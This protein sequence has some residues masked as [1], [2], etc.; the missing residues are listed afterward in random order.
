MANTTSII[1]YIRSSEIVFN[2]VNLKP[3]KTAHFFFDGTL[4]DQFI[5]K[6]SVIT[7][8]TSDVSF[9]FK[10]NEGLYCSNTRSYA[11]VVSTS[12]NNIIY[13]NDNY[14]SLNVSPFD[15]VTPFNTDDFKNGD[16]VFTS[17]SASSNISS[18][19]Y[20]ARVQYFNSTDKVLVVRSLTG[21][22]NTSP[23]IKSLYNLSNAKRAN[24]EN[25]FISTSRFPAVN[26]V[27]STSN[28]SNSIVVSTYTHNHGTVSTLNSSPSVLN[29]LSSPP[30]DITSKNAYI[31][32]GTGFPNSF[33]VDTVS[34]TTV[35]N[36]AFSSSAITGVSTYSL[37]NIIVDDYGNVAGIFQLPENSTYRF[38][39]GQRLFTVTD[40]LNIADPDNQMKASAEYVAGGLLQ[41]IDKVQEKITPVVPP[42]PPAPPINR[43]VR[44]DTFGG[45]RGDPVAQT[46][47][48]P[49]DENGNGLGVFVSSVDLFFKNKPNSSINDPQLPVSVK[50]VKTLNGYPT[51]EIIAEVFV[52]CKDVNVTNGITTFPSS[53]DS[54]TATKFPFKDPVYLAPGEEYALVVYSDSPSYEVWISELGQTVIGDTNNRRISEQP[55]TGSFF[56]SQNA[57]TWTPFQ[58]QDLMFIVNKAVFNTSSSGSMVFNV[59][60]PIANVGIHNMTIHSNQ[61]VFSNTSLNYNY[62]T[63]LSST[64]ALEVAYSPIQE[65]K[66]F[67]FSSDLKTSSLST[68]RKRVVLSG[69]AN[70][71]FV[72]MTFGTSDNN[73]SPVVNRERLSLI[74]EE[75]LINDGGLANA[76]IT[77]TNGGGQHTNVANLR[78]VITGP[79]LFS[80]DPTSTANATVLVSDLVSG[81]ITQITVTNAGR[82]YVESPTITITDLSPGVTA[83]ATAVVVSEDGKSGGNALARY[84]TKRIVLADGFDAGDMR[85]YVECVRPQ[86]THVI[87]YYKVLS[88]SDPDSFDNKNWKRMYLTNDIISQDTI[89]PVEL[90]FQ[91]SSIEGS[92]S[93]VE[94]SVT[95]PLGGSFKYFAIK[96]VMLA[97]DPS[98]PPIIR[99]LRAIALPAG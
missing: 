64:G 1:P 7:T 91:P 23:T 76:N 98:V 89:T 32:S 51:Q 95:Y 82:G 35:A 94:N 60:P 28:S 2:A 53:S 31:T 62:R 5:Q 66:I 19:T 27:V 93:Y 20:S 84:L 88:D 86:G 96:L 69:N 65:N 57:S 46:F 47:F 72:Q 40:T 63:T 73:I 45:L 58:N 61:I 29:L 44:R 15:G 22:V 36:S 9:M 92:L 54:T 43:F 25:V 77:I 11:T 68:N 80:E 34:G 33:R 26:T 18:N 16:V 79:Q 13:I 14:V 3:G 17:P 87:A 42:T 71:L 52:P 97:S 56:R 85:V 39:T 55:Y 24:I 4:V 90:V 10:T 37:G 74:S 49:N 41:T 12:S 70:S 81:N 21:T 50:I 67:N 75:Y 48:T 59:L 6:A 99:N 83:N 30:P 78:I 38:K 8:N